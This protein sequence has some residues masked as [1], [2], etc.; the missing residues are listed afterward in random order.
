MDLDE[1]MSKVY[2]SANDTRERRV[3]AALVCYHDAGIQYGIGSPEEKQ[4]YTALVNIFPEMEK[5]CEV[6]NNLRSTLSQERILP[7]EGF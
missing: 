2:V 7:P 1:M 6:M 5:L 4:A 3:N